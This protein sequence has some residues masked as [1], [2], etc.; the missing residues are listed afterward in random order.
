LNGSTF[1]KAGFCFANTGTRSRQYIRVLHPKRPIL[2]E[3]DNALFGGTNFGFARSVVSRTKSRIA[4]LEGPS[5]HEG[6]APLEVVVCADAETDASG[7][8]KTGSSVNVKSRTRRSIAER[9]ILSVM[10]NSSRCGATAIFV[11]AVWHVSV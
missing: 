6:S 3:S 9:G 7:P 1:F 5:F 2:I 8:D 11:T 10:F 4:C